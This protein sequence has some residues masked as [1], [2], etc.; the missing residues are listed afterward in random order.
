[1]AEQK[2]GMIRSAVNNLVKVIC[3]DEIK[4]AIKEA[5]DTKINKEIDI[6][7]DK[8]LETGIKDIIEK[9]LISKLAPVFKTI[10]NINIPSVVKNI[11]N[12]G[13]D[14][15]INRLVEKCNKAIEDKIKANIEALKIKVD[16][17]SCSEEINKLVH[18]RVLDII[19]DDEEVDTIIKQKVIESIK[20]GNNI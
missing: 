7:I 9:S 17:G 4:I 8:L 2:T 15:N 16:V 5:V 1:M 20:V 3:D 10:E 18:E 11:A 6:N 12:M 13:V 14:D 19:E